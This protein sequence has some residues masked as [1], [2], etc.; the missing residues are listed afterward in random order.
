M[1]PC[2]VAWNRVPSLVPVEIADAQKETAGGSCVILHGIAHWRHRARTCTASVP[3]M[4]SASG[5]LVC[6]AVT[7]TV[8]ELGGKQRWT[9]TKKLLRLPSTG[10]SWNY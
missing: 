10:D 8:I 5:N 4:R 2:R 6:A 7:T 9:R 1:V 3:D